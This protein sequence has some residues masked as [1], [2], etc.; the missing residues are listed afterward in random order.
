MSEKK[1]PDHFPFTK[2]L[3]VI[4]KQYVG[5]VS[6]K[7]QSLEIDRAFYALMLIAESNCQ[8]TQQMLTDKLNTDKVCMV[9]TIDYLSRKG[10]ARRKKNPNDR[11]EHLL[12]VTEK[13]KAVI[14]KIRQVFHETNQEAFHGLSQE[15]ITSFLQSLDIIKNN[16]NKI[17][18]IDVRLN[19]N[20]NRKVK[21]EN[22]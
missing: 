18:A 9:R 15:E 10:Y 21:K 1:T 3:A 5:I 20:R 19:F 2:H 6:E 13:G 17:P 14:P 11:R 8:L 7:L 4:T 16:L 12:E 22:T